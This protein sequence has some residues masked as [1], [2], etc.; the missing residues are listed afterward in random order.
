MQLVHAIMYVIF[1]FSASEIA[2]KAPLITVAFFMALSKGEKI[3]YALFK[4]KEN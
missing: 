3:F 4:I 2:A 1:V